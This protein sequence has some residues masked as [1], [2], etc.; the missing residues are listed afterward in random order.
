MSFMYILQ[1]IALKVHKY[2]SLHYSLKRFL[3]ILVIRR[4]ALGYFGGFC[5]ALFY[6]LAA[7]SFSF[8]YPKNCFSLRSS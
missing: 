5:I 8:A 6:S 3:A 4:K 7:F 1:N 2:I